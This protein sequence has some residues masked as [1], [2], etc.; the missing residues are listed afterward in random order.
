MVETV[1]NLRIKQVVPE[2]QEGIVS[3]GERQDT[4]N[5]S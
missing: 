3:A 1:E 5:Q 2:R 4:T